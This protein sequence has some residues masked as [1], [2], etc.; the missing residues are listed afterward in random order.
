MP[1]LLGRPLIYS[2]SWVDY[3]QKLTSKKHLLTYTSKLMIVVKFLDKTSDASLPLKTSN[4]KRNFCTD[5]KERSTRIFKFIL[6]YMFFPLLRVG[7]TK[8]K[9]TENVW[10]WKRQRSDP[11]KRIKSSTRIKSHEQVKSVWYHGR[12]RLKL[13]QE[14]VVG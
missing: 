4:S 10:V 8:I 6:I 7:E 12:A 1:Y 3:P 2:L 5:K 13:C 11:R 14:S 9:S